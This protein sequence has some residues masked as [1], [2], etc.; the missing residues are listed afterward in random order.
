MRT[1]DVL[2]ATI[3]LILSLFSTLLFVFLGVHPEKLDRNRALGLSVQYCNRNKKVPAC[4]LRID[5]LHL[6]MSARVPPIQVKQNSP[7][8]KDTRHTKTQ[9][10][11][12]YSFFQ[13]N[14]QSSWGKTG[15]RSIN[16]NKHPGYQRGVSPFI[17]PKFRI[18][19]QISSCDA[20]TS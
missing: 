13:Y 15:T 19:N 10:H 5:T 3:H 11:R 2:C 8:F 16:S 12:H 7:S 14:T 9:P 17:H 20:G 4:S 6:H 1:N 18:L